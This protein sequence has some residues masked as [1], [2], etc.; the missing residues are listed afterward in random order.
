[1]ADNSTLATLKVIIDGTVKPF[2]D[3]CKEAISE[4]QKAVKDINKILDDVDPIKP[5]IDPNAVRDAA[6]EAEKVVTAVEEKMGEG[7]SPT[8]TPSVTEPNTATPQPTPALTDSMSRIEKMKLALRGLA[9]EAR[10]LS[11]IHVYTDDYQHMSNEMYEA[12]QRAEALRQSMR[13]MVLLGDVDSDSYREMSSELAQVEDRAT[14][15]RNAVVRLLQD[16]GA[17]KFSGVIGAIKN[18]TSNISGLGKRLGQLASGALNKAGG[19]FKSLINRMKE[20]ISHLNIFKRSAGQSGGVGSLVKQ[21]LKAGIAFK[22][23]SAAAN[24][25]KSAIKEGFNNMAAANV[26]GVNQ[27][28]SMLM[29]SLAQLRNA[30]ATAFAPIFTYIAPALNY[31][32]QLAVSA[33]SAIGKLFAALT[34]K[35]SF[36]SAKNVTQSYGAALDGSAASAGEAKEANEEYKKSLMGFDEINKVEDNKTPSTPS[37]GGGGGGGGGGIDPSSMFE[38][39]PIDGAISDFA[40]KIKE[41]WKNADFTEIGGIV[42]GKLRDALNQIPWGPIQNIC[43]KIAK[44][45]ATFLN[46]FFETPGLFSAIGRTVGMSLNTALGTVHT[47]LDNLHTDSIGRALTTALQETFRT[48]D[49]GMIGRV[50]SDIPKKFFDFIRGGIEGIDWSAL[51]YEIVQKIKD[52]FAGYDFRGVAEAFGAMLGAAC[53]AGIDLAGSIWDML[54]EAWNGTKAYF[55]GYIR[56]AGGDVIT[57]LYNGIRDAIRN[58]GSWIRKNI[59]DPFIKGFK[60]AFGI[61]SP[62]RVMKTQGGYIID[63]LLQ[64]AKAKVNILITWFRGLPNRIKNAIGNLLSLG[65]SITGNFMSGLLSGASSR[66][67]SLISWFRGIPGHIRNAIGSLFSIGQSIISGFISGFRSLHIPTPHVSITWENLTVA[68]VPTPIKKPNFSLS[69]YAAGGFPAQGQMF[70]A[71]ESGPELVG[72]MGNRTAVANNDQIVRGIAQAVGP[73]VYEGVVAA[74]AQSSGNVSVYLQGDANKLFKVIREEEKKYQKSN[75]KNAFG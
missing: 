20:G 58:V 34:G 8:I 22:A 17:T 12:D 57:G 38:T 21:I 60:S 51:P 5:G 36:V 43:N 25:A 50:L 59:F 31:L 49:F 70:V 73:A 23:L 26:G 27:S 47:F 69:W 61:S 42:G 48:L 75:Y 72:T 45:T 14:R 4:A 41:A 9:A 63:G 19:A 53:R 30:L 40:K 74:M 18:V 46:G 56:E 11:G 24:W 64:G 15:A 66:L 37:G 16:G 68:G 65:K 35:S 33:A 29:S 3:V 67:A 7:S 62:S 10:V 55:E 71:R 54:K 32:I 52:F 28:L 2:K 1:M 13:D 39:V 44:S 6:S